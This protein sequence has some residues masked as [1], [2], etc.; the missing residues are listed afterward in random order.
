MVGVVCDGVVRGVCGV[1]WVW[2]VC[3]CVITT[4]HGSH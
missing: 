2:H 1:W 3:T 4:I